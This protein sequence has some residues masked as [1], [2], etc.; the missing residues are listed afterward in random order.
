VVRGD[1]HGLRPGV[2]GEGGPWRG[3]RRVDLAKVFE[4]RAS[5]GQDRAGDSDAYDATT[6][7]AAIDYAA[8]AG[9]GYTEE[10]VVRFG[11]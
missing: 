4:A 9:T 11:G 8:T 5:T 1:V 2:G 3:I 6:R 7:S 10:A